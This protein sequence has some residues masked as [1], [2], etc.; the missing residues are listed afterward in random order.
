MKEMFYH[1]KQ[2]KKVKLIFGRRNRRIKETIPI[3]GNKR[4]PEIWLEIFNNG[5]S[6]FVGTRYRRGMDKYEICYYEMNCNFLDLDRE[7]RE[8]IWRVFMK[9]INWNPEMVNQ[10][11]P[12]TKK[13]YKRYEEWLKKVENSKNER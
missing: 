10:E 1:N 3:Y 11:I 9:D 8:Q 4:F 6:R 2:G 12:V 5:Q 7:M 13:G